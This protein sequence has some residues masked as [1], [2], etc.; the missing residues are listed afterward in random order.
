VYDAVV[1]GSGPNGLAAALRLAQAGWKVLVVEAKATPGGGMRTAELT[2]PGF[3]H[4]VCSAILPLGMGSPYLRTLGL[5]RFGLSWVHSPAAAAHPL[6]G[7]Q[8]VL[9]WR[10]LEAT[11]AS[12][13]VGGEAWR[14]LIGP[15]AAEWE[16][17]APMVLGP[18]P[19]PRHPVLLA[20]FGL[21][22]MLPASVLARAALPGVRQQALFGGLAA[23]SMLSLAQ[24]FTASFGLV[25]G[26]LGHAVGWPFPRGG[27]Q[28][29]TDALVKLLQTLGGD[30]VAGWTVRRLEELPRARAVLLDVTPRQL[31][32]L[33]GD[34]LPPRYRRQLRRYQYGAAAFKV[35]Y[36]LDGPVPWAA[37]EC[38]LAATVHLGGTL[39][40]IEASERAVWRGEH[41]PNPF[42]LAVQPSLFDPTR[43]PAGQH[44]L[45][46]YCHT[47]HASTV[48]MTAAIEA[49]IERFAPS[50][51][52]RVLA[53]KVH[54]PADLEA[55]NPNY[56]GG[57]IDGGM[58]NWRQL[59]TRPVAQWNPYR[60][61]LPGVYLCSSSTPPGGGV[62][63]MCG[64]HAAGAVLKEHRA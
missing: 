37:P 8:A 60:T 29:L 55:Y 48:D 54:T 31:L 4:D 5:E 56:V 21:A 59:W 64:Y 15:L 61:P 41:P 38:S 7:G 25:L 36:A 17:L 58:Q 34:R 49:Q 30:V 63:G 62:H 57:D 35:D 11:I 12:I 9:L 24:P 13:G 1:V 22:A 39:P 20:R 19:W 26:L 32:A 50:F 33:A 2:L 27:A 46:A 6:D 18:V 42:V 3:H 52:E 45:W 53:R 10:E 47:P 51:R 16:R 28:E 40:E 43:A 44:T 14:R 23:H